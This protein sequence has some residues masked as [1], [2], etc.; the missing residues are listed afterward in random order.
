VT[1]IHF[2]DAGSPGV[3]PAGVRAVQ[4]ACAQAVALYGSDLLWDP[5]EGSGRDDVQLLLNRQA[6]SSL[7]ALP[8]TPRGTHK[9]D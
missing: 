5:E 7:G 9:R 4:I 3:A 6:R 8:T 2:A 1:K